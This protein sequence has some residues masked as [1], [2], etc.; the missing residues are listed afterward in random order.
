MPV[1]LFTRK[2]V[3]KGEIQD[4][5]QHGGRAFQ[6]VHYTEAKLEPSFA[7]HG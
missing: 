1:K 2:E 7:T 4:S 6:F 5:H 3:G